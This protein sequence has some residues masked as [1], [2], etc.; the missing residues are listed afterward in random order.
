MMVARHTK[1]TTT[2]DAM[3]VQVVSFELGRMT[4][5]NDRRRP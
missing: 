4:E 2:E 3:Y 1:H 5:N